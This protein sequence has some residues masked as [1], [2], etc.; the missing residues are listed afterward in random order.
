[1]AE[2]KRTPLTYLWEFIQN[3]LSPVFVIFFQVA[4]IVAM[5]VMAVGAFRFLNQPF[6][7]AMIEHTLVFNAIQPMQPGTWNAKEQ[8][9]RFGDV[10]KAVNGDRIYTVRGYLETIRDN[11]FGD[12]VILT[13]GIP[14]G[15]EREVG[16][17]LQTFPGA[18]RV[19]YLYVPYLIGIVYLGSGLWVLSLRRVDHA[20]RV[21]SVFTASIAVVSAGFFD[22]GTSNN[23]VYLWTFC[24]ALA[25]GAL[26]NLALIFPEEVEWAKRYPLLRWL[27]YFPAVVLAI[28]AYPT[29]YNTRDPFAYFIPWRL[30]YIY[31]GFSVVLFISLAIVRR[32]RSTSPITRQQAQVIILGSI[33]AFSPLSI[34]FFITTIRPEVA[35]TP[36]LILPLAIFPL[37]IGYA[38]LRHRLLQTDYLLSRAV[39]FALLSILA[40]GG[41]AM[42]VSGLSLV[43][44]DTF[45]ASN[46]FI[47]GFMIFILAILFN[48]LRIRLQNFINV[49]FFR[50]QRV[51]QEREQAF[52]QELNPTMGLNDIVLYLR[53]YIDRSLGP[54]RL[55]IFVHDSLRDIYIST[56]DDSGKTTTDISFSLSSAL[57]RLLAQRNTFIMLSDDQVLPEALESDKTRLA[58]LGAELFVPLPGRSEHVIGFLALGLRRSGEIYSSL[59][60]NLLSS[61]CDQASLAIERAQVVADLERRVHEMNVLIRVA[62]GIN[63][64]LR[65]DDILELIYAQTIRLIPSKDF[66]IMLYDN[67]SGIFQY[68]FY[69]ESD[70]RLLNYERRPWGDDQ[71]LAQAVV[72][73]RRAIVTD[74]YERECRRRGYP[75]AV[76]GLYAWMGV[77]LN[78]GA[79]TIGA[80][81][82]GSRDPSVIYTEEQIELLQAIADQAAGAI[83]KAR[84]LEESERNARQLEMLN[85]L[86][87]SLTSTLD[88]PL[89][90]NQILESATDILNCEAGTLFLVDQETGELVFEVVTG[91]VA[92]EL[93]GKRLPPG[94]GHVGK[95]VETGQAAIVNEARRTTDWAQAPDKQTGFQTRDLLLA[96]MQV[97]D[98]IVGVIEVIN[99]KDGQPFT[100]EDQSLLAAFASSAAVALENARLYTLTDQQ[101]ADRVD[102]LSVMQRIDRELNASLDVSRAM[103]ITLDWAMRQ[104]NADA[105]L[106]GAVEEDGVRVMAAQGY[107]SELDAYHDSLLPLDLPGLHSAVK[108][109]ATQRFS[110]LDATV[111]DG[112]SLLEGARGQVVIPIRREEQVIGVLMLESLQTELWSEDTQAFLSRLSDHAAISIANA[113]LFSQVQAADVAKSDFISFVSHEL[114]TP[115][116]SIRG[117]TDLLVGGAVG[118]INEAQMNFLGTIRSNVTRMATLVS[119][120][121][122]V[123]RIEAGRLRLEFQGVAIADVIQEVVRSQSRD[124]EEK[125]QDLVVEVPEGLPRIWGDQTRLVQILTNLVSNAHKY[126]P[127]EG[128][129]VIRA[130]KSDNMWDPEG[131]A[132]VVWVSVEDNGIGMTSEDQENI[133]EKFFRSED[134]KAREAP[135]TGLGLN[136]TQYLVEMQGGK[137]WFESEYGKGTTFHFTIPVAEV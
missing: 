23:L 21:F 105:G 102:E 89:L 126:T 29:I 70:R 30:E 119:D 8:G 47:I 85:E 98:T 83:V 28:I 58:L 9:I 59:D 94:T 63:I 4:V 3:R 22:L 108:D 90:L 74:D 127:E 15:D 13:V 79:E 113:Q 129:I 60:L 75:P 46:P 6:V 117:Y 10:L 78:A 96:P 24:L 38:M 72:L 5:G 92:N 45:N 73:N 7:G 133:F 103:R 53:R 18:D 51:Y 109:E 131:A 52:S 104:S 81:S 55:H 88:L 71:G 26:I 124:L 97:Q 76:E 54:T 1:M 67:A 39:L 101:L 2:K 40:V 68:V 107:T 128:R 95:A 44:G 25:G 114:K 57:P 123:S 100:S 77:P 122:D 32:L 69:L 80:L 110:S 17:V 49:I 11:K 91:P 42:L 34:W 12:D 111:K 41:Y 43:I 134:P 121:A 87:R 86:G 130:K 99:K 132:E 137:I 64:T 82:L 61:L 56:E 36:I 37:A 14:D 84:L 35:F 120:L 116:T 27:G 112:F 106:V 66:W 50:G 16:V 135:G 65:F 48:P 125:N 115:M 93:L 118:S 20:G 62:Q 33:L 31:L 136:I 19:A